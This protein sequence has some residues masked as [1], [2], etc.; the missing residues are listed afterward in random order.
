MISIDDVVRAIPEQVS[1]DLDE[2]VVILG[3]QDGVY[4]GLD[5]VGARVWAIIQEPHAVREIRDLLIQEY[6][7][8]GQQCEADVLAFLEQLQNWGLIK[9]GSVT[10]PELVQDLTSG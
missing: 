4:Y 7:V 2:E 10:S 8:T 1:C 9:V 6:D 5:P 3:L